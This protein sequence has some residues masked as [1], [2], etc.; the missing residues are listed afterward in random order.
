MLGFFG[1]VVAMVRLLLPGWSWAVVLGVAGAITAPLALAFIYERLSALKTPWFEISLAAGIVQEEAGLASALKDQTLYGGASANPQLIDS[2]SALTTP[3]A[4][5]VLLIDLGDWWST[6]IFLLAALTEDYT[7]AKRLVF[8]EGGAA[9]QYVG[10]ATPSAVRAVFASRFPDYEPAYFFAKQSEGVGEPKWRVANLVG[11]WQLRLWEARVKQTPE[12]EDPHEEG[13]IEPPN[14]VELRNH[15]QAV[16]RYVTSAELLDWL[17]DVLDTS[18]I[19]WDRWLED[20]RLRARILGQDESYIALVQDGRLD[21]VVS[22][23]ELALAVS[24]Q[25]VE[26]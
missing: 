5:K 17:T 3:T 13:V 15:E 19:T 16:K 23:D 14:Q 7:A 8:V 25:A 18:C 2:I 9:R 10:M 6:R 26:V 20:P 12:P 24:R 1:A 21:R 22:R 11:A 4:P